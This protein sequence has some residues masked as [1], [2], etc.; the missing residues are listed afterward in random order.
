MA[1]GSD[2]SIADSIQACASV[3][4]ASHSRIKLIRMAYMR[5][6][7]RGRTAHGEAGGAC[8]RLHETVSNGQL[9]RF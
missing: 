4:Q 7:H 8:L 5:F 9:K 1:G 3:R 6:P 2:Q